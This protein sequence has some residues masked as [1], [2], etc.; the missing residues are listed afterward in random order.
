M[1]HNG[2]VSGHSKSTRIPWVDGLPTGPSD[3]ECH[4]ILRKDLID[5]T[6]IF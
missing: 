5:M 6:G 4:K 2:V 3:F 1:G